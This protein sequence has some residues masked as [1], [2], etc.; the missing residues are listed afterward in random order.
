MHI[1]HTVVIDYINNTS[2]T[3]YTSQH[4]KIHLKYIFFQP[5]S[6]EGLRCGNLAFKTLN[7]RSSVCCIAYKLPPQC[8]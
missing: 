6:Q 7:L 1:V 3:K 5:A 4:I 2:Y 8:T